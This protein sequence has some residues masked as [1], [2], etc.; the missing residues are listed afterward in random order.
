MTPEAQR[1]AII[2][3]AILAGSAIIGLGL[4]AGL[5]RPPLDARSTGDSTGL[6]DHTSTPP[7]SPTTAPAVVGA[8][9]PSVF[10]ASAEART[11]QASAELLKQLTPVLPALA[12]QCA[13]ALRA[14][15]SDASRSTYLLKATFDERGQL[16]IRGFS[17]TANS[18][19]GV[20][21]CLNGSSAFPLSITPTGVVTPIEVEFSLPN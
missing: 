2:T 14:N 8:A 19:P 10:A 1:T 12:K 9:A 17:R 3:V 5:R 4:F 7:G 15:P 6:A 18:V 20:A 11:S 21:S 13:T 16:L